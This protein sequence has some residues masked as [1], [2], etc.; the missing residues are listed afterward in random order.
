[1]G[2]SKLPRAKLS[3]TQLLPNMCN[4]ELV[5]LDQGDDGITFT[6]KVVAD[7]FN[8][9]NDSGHKVRMSAQATAE[10]R[11]VVQNFYRYWQASNHTIARPISF[12]FEVLVGDS[13]DEL[14]AGAMSAS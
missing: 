12:E 4:G 9:I 1:M 11:A 2:T 10:W 5:I 8:L 3:I 7:S 6:F 14:L 13:L